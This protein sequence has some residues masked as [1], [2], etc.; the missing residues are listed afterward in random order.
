MTGVQYVAGERRQTPRGVR[1]GGG[2]KDQHPEKLVRK[3]DDD[4]CDATEPL[5]NLKALDRGFGTKVSRESF[6]D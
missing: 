5:R 6:A 3:E 1:R 2:S 4:A